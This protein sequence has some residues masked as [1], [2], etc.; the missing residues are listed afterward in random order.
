M[1]LLSGGYSVYRK[2]G[3]RYVQAAG[4]IQMRNFRRN[5]FAFELNRNED[6]LIS[7]LS[8]E[9][10]LG[11]PEARF[12]L[13][14][15]LA[16]TAGFEELKVPNMIIEEPDIGLF[17][18]ELWTREFLFTDSFDSGQM[19]KLT[20]LDMKISKYIANPLTSQLEFSDSPVFGKIINQCHIKKPIAPKQP[21]QSPQ[22]P[23]PQY[24]NWGTF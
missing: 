20:N 22:Q 17:I 4:E 11:M 9:V 19:E 8:T 2:G 18:K 13:N 10:N 23:Q 7:V 5:C 3:W 21:G 16:L 1:A 14:S 6:G 15:N 12:K 24:D